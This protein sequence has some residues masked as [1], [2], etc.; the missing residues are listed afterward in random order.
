MQEELEHYFLQHQ[1][2]QQQLQHAEIRWQRMLQRTPDYCDYEA[3]EVL[4]VQNE[5]NSSIW[6]LKNLTIAGRQLPQ[7]TFKLIPEQGIAGFV[8]TKQADNKS[9]F[10]RWPANVKTEKE[11]TLILVGKE[12]LIHQRIESLLELSVSDWDFIKALCCFIEDSLKQPQAINLPLE[13]DLAALSVGL[14]TLKNLFEKFPALLRYDQL[15]IK[16]E[17]INPDYEHLW[18]HITQ[19]AYGNKR[20]PEFEFRLSCANVRPNHFGSHPKLEFPEISS[21]N[22]LESWFIEAYDDF[23]AKLELRFAM[24]AAMDIEV[25][26]RLSD[27]DKNFLVALI[28]RLPNMLGDLQD[29]GVK[30]KRPW[31]DWIDMAQTMLSILTPHLTPPIVTRQEEPVVEKPNVAD[32]FKANVALPGKPKSGQSNKIAKNQ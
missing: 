7:L 27:A 29:A 15:S 24:P 12:E 23:G 25:W 5:N 13:L 17:Q 22:V 26:H 8:F 14:N 28:A 20:W 4:P 21:Q 18:L 3:L 32:S 2:A 19:L 10:I 1:A 11:L 16:R 9:P 31:Q 30:I 6:Q